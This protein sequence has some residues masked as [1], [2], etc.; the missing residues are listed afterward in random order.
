M[1]VSVR[2]QV[3]GV[4]LADQATIEMIGAS[5]DLA[6]ALW[7]EVDGV[8]TATVYPTLP[9]DVTSEIIRFARQVTAALP[10]ARV[11][12][13]RRDLVSASDVA[14]RTGF[15]RE[16]V[17]KWNRAGNDRQFPM[18][19]G[20][21]GEGSRTSKVWLWSEVAEWLISSYCLP[22]EVD[23]PSEADAAHIDACLAKVPDYV[24]REWHAIGGTA[25]GW[26]QAIAR[27]T[28]GN[29][30]APRIQA[31]YLSGPSRGSL[32]AGQAAS[33]A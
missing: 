7:S 13:V 2:L 16:T 23:W 26:E 14:H 25:T 12:R 5:E 9:T 17:R 24:S 27:L 30:A 8:V 31:T 6:S 11:R 15:S 29:I 20:A 22:I 32:E 21:V 28:I 10:G 33:H 19:V 18:P 3:E 4:D 1:A